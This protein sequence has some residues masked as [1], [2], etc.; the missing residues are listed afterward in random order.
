MRVTRCQWNTY[1]TRSFESET[2][3]STGYPNRIVEIRIFYR[4]NCKAFDSLLADPSKPSHSQGLHNLARSVF[5]EQ[6]RK[7][8]A[9]TLSIY[10]YSSL[11]RSAN[12]WL[13]CL[14][15]SCI[16]KIHLSLLVRWQ[17]QWIDFS[18]VHVLIV[19]ISWGCSR[20][21]STKTALK[22]SNGKFVYKIAVVLIYFHTLWNI[23]RQRFR[24]LKNIFHFPE[25]K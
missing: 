3:R 17:L 13:I 4:D 21:R 15:R 7:M 8:S 24:E 6:P 10:W 20:Y 25:W 22:C 19:C 11:H 12:K 16:S 23:W 14:L 5:D 1:F 18:N 9:L 2:S